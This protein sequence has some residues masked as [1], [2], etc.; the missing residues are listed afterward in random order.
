M[1]V[2]NDL[3]TGARILRMIQEAGVFQHLEMQ[4]IANV[5]EMIRYDIVDGLSE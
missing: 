1:G 4:R 3:K 2:L 5:R